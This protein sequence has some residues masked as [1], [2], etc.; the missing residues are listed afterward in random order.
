[1]EAPSGWGTNF[2][3]TAKTITKIKSF[4]RPSSEVS[5]KVI[6]FIQDAKE[7]GRGELHTV[8]AVHNVYYH[9]GVDGKEKNVKDGQIPPLATKLLAPRP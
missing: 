4:S 9:I 6:A 3:N 1:M 7:R 5:S 8:A 2:R